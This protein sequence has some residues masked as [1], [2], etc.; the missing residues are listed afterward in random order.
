MPFE[1]FDKKTM[2]VSK[3][4]YL[5]LQKGGTMSLN[6]RAFLDLGE[7]EAVELLFDRDEQLIGLKPT[8]PKE[9]YAF[10]IRPQGSRNRVSNY[11]VAGQAF[12][13]HY[14]I[15]TSVA[16]RYLAEMRDDTLVVDLKSGGA[17][18]TGPRLGQTKKKRDE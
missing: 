12:T 3:A 14:D 13:K 4:P 7:P 10:P 5:T 9:P 8:S 1:R 17:I 15:D 6:R 11:A 16:R 18:A 2:T